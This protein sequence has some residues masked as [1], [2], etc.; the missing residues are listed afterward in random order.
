MR[1]EETTGRMPAGLPLTDEE[2]ARYGRHIILPEIAIEG[3][4]RL[5]AGSILI[6]GAGGLGSPLALYLAA[7]G[8]GR[9]GIVDPDTVDRSN[10]Q[11]Q[12]LFATSDIGVPKARAAKRKIEEINPNVRAEAFE[13]RLRAEN[14]L[15]ILGGYDLVADA[16]DN[17]PSRYLVNDACV[18]LG[19]PNVHG[20]I[21]RF[22][23]QVAVFDARKGP[24]YRCLYPEP[25]PP[26]LIPSCAEAGVLGVLPGL[27]GMI[28][29]TEAL[30]LLLG[31]GESLG[32][33][34]LH[35]DALRLRFR[36]I[37]LRKDPRCPVCGENPSIRALTDEDGEAEP[38]E[39]PGADLVRDIDSR[40]LKQRLEK[41]DPLLLLDV[42]EPHEERICRLPGSILVPL[43]ELQGRV[44]EIEPE[45]E[46]VVYCHVG[47]RSRAAALFLMRRGFPRVW[48]LA[49]GITAWAEEVDPAMQTY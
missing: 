30:K 48:N 26:G 3:Q 39:E 49:G 38:C 42:R 25:P 23:G 24:C 6:V 29:A 11:R 45:R 8:V 40:T 9:I 44:E 41:Q 33:R 12:V 17:F 2:I 35:Y 31:I 7:S 1:D 36:E 18:L 16:T 13:T 27:V 4:G 46:I 21:F 15:E 37:K 10:L 22:D 34:L 20:S 5:K 47:V 32:G 28:Q 19:K 43:G 14:A